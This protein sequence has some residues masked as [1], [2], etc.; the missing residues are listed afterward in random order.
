MS[1]LQIWFAKQWL[2]NKN[3]TYQCINFKKGFFLML[4]NIFES[5]CVPASQNCILFYWTIP[6]RNHELILQAQP[7]VQER[8]MLF[9]QDDRVKG[10][11]EY[12]YG[13]E[14]DNSPSGSVVWVWILHLV[15]PWT[16]PEHRWTSTLSS[17][18]GCP[19]RLNESGSGHVY[20]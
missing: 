1:S 18:L 17:G 13:P 11:T 7:S 2:T 15:L 16:L 10:F 19:P 9:L 8:T 14:Y 4:R 6:L 20:F 12:K 3:F 5:C